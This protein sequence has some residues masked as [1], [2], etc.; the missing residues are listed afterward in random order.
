V[1]DKDGQLKDIEFPFDRTQDTA[2]LIAS[3]LVD[4]QLVAPPDGDVVARAIDY[5]IEHPSSSET[6]FLISAP[7]DLTPDEENLV[8]YAVLVRVET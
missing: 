5:L 7:A 3:E 6:R 2:A 1:R 8:G 4:A